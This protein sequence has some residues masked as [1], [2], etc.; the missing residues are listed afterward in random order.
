METVITC[1]DGAKRSCRSLGASLEGDHG[2][3]GLLHFQNTQW[4]VLLCHTFLLWHTLPCYRLKL[5]DRLEPLKPFS[6]YKLITSAL[7][8]R[9]RNLTNGSSCST[10]PHTPFFLLPSLSLSVSVSPISSSLTS[11]FP[12]GFVETVFTILGSVLGNPYRS[13]QSYF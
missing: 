5:Y 2:V 4:A 10:V 7:C 6:Q 8:G 9:E 3:Q 13:S 1:R 11:H 12:A